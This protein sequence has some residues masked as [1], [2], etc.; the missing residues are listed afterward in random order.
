M[1]MYWYYYSTVPGKRNVPKVQNMYHFAC[2]LV[3]YMYSYRTCPLLPVISEIDSA[4][5]ATLP[6]E[7]LPAVADFVVFHSSRCP[8]AALR[9]YTGTGLTTLVHVYYNYKYM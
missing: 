2:V 8:T 3:Q 5:H 4:S 7:L 6:V 9:V 1:Y